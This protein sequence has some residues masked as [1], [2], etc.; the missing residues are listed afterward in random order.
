[1]IETN[2]SPPNSKKNQKGLIFQLPKNLIVSNLKIGIQG[3]IWK[4]CL[5]RHTATS[6]VSLHGR[7]KVLN[8]LA[9]YCK[10]QPN[11]WSYSTTQTSLSVLTHKWVESQL[12]SGYCDQPNNQPNFPFHIPAKNS[13]GVLIWLKS[14]TQLSR[15]F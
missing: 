12:N 4:E 9:F 10:Q 5:L 1:M 6:R 14:S 3:S 15:N 8:I 7:K 13:L 2:F 11:A